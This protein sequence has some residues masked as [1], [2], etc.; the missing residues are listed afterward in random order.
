MKKFNSVLF[1]RTMLLMILV[2]LSILSLGMGVKEF[3][4]AGFL[5]GQGEDVSLALISRIPRLVSILVTGASLSIAGL[6]MQTITSNK[7]VSPATAGT[8]EWCKFGVLVAMLLAGGQSKMIKIICAFLISL[9]GTM[10][11]MYMLNKI[12][13]KNMILVP[14][15]GMMLGNV[16]GSVTSYFAYKYDI[17]QNMSSW[18]QGNFSL[19]LKGNYELLYIGI[20]FLFI[21]YLYANKFTIAGMG[22]GFATSLGLNHKAIVTIGMVIVAFITSVTVVTIGSIPFIG[23]IVPNIVAMYRGDNLKNTL[24]DTAIFGALFVLICDM[25]GRKILAPY[26]VS[27]SVVVSIVGSIIFL[28][29]LTRKGNKG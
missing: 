25:I 9:L 18:L 5:M 22:D 15:V 21:A 24:F 26:E 7:F 19:V 20:P 14:L 8:M 16:V 28:F 12:K 2:L 4:I 10:F 29:L 6:I 23:L 3:S 1:S 11:F 13:F 27:I 17:V